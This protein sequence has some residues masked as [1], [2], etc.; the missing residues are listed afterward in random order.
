M[1]E[2]NLIDIDLEKM[3]VAFNKK[4]LQSIPVKQLRKVHKVFID[5]TRETSKFGISSDPGLDPR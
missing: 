4:E 1:D 3:E 5:S 2:Q